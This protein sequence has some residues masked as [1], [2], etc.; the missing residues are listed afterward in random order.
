MSKVINVSDNLGKLLLEG[1]TPSDRSCLVEG[2]CRIPLLRSPEGHDPVIWF[3]P[4]C[5]DDGNVRDPGPSRSE[6][7]Q[8]P[9]SPSLA[10]STHYSP[11]STPPTE[12]SHEAR[13]PLLPYPRRQQSDFA[14][15]EI[16]K[17][18]LKG[19]AMLADECPGS[20]CYGIPLV[21]PPTSGRDKDPKKE[22]VVCGMIYVTQKMPQGLDS[23][24]PV[25]PSGPMQEE[26]NVH[27]MGSNATAKGK[28]KALD[29]LRAA[30]VVPSFSPAIRASS[31]GLSTAPGF[32]AI[33]SIVQESNPPL[34]TSFN[35]EPIP[36]SD[37]IL[38][39]SDKALGASLSAL[40]QRLLLLSG[41]PFLDPIA[42]SQTADA[43]SSTGKALAVI[44]A[45]RRNQE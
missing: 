23:L 2:C 42:I 7:Q 3:C 25:M 36:T 27:T 1:W 17:R 15:A 33:T 10:S 28:E 43:I 31:T 22:C 5:E 16:G 11:A 12:I 18:L 8:Q 30:A 24:L 29:D 14:S 39:S 35:P 38:A 4:S 9:S 20:T 37:N 13:S 26:F 34:P 19:W 21:R 44:N 40:S 32:S 6:P 45:L 41:Q